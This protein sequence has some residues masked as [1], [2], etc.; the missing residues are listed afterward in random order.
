[1]YSQRLHNMLPA[2]S[3]EKVIKKDE[4][5]MLLKIQ[6]HIYKDKLLIGCF[7][8]IIYSFIYTYIEYIYNRNIC[9]Y[10]YI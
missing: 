5:R 9:I 8:G 3:K 1:M 7:S 10:M 6:K 4:E 2:D